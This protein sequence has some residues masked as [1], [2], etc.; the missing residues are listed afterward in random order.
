METARDYVA[1]RRHCA[2]IAARLRDW[3]EAQVAQ[4]S[5]D[6]EIMPQGVEEMTAASSTLMA[7]MIPDESGVTLRLLKA[8]DIRSCLG[9]GSESVRR[10]G[11]V[12]M[13]AQHC[14]S[15]VFPE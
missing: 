12:E 1:R 9:R 8:R 3:Y 13:V 6:A 7:A 14:S 11:Q 10:L 5:L 2:V 4:C 15:I